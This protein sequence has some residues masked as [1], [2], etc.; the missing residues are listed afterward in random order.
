MGIN[1]I[2]EKKKQKKAKEAR[3]QALKKKEKVRAENRIKKQTE[4]AAHKTRE[5]LVP[6][7]NIHRSKGK[8]SDQDV[9]KQLKHN[10]EILK[11]MEEEYLKDLE[12]KK[13]VNDQLES[14]GLTTLKEKLDALE[15]KVK[16]K[17]KEGS[18]EHHIGDEDEPTGFQVQ[19][20]DS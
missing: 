1:K 14:E 15:K 20:D 9:I 4:R 2:R 12:A 17:L 7:V 5:R 8:K 10:L 3:D 18:F 11:A 19:E 16:D 13:N 6:I